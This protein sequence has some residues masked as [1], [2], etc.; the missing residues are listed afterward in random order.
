MKELVVKI[1]D[2][3]F[4]GQDSFEYKNKV[5]LLDFRN[6]ALLFSDLEKYGANIEKAF[7]EFIILKEG[8]QFPF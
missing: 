6:L 4:K 8:E 1:R 3:E 5:S 2:K 7:R